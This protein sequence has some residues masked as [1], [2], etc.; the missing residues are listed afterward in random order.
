MSKPFPIRIRTFLVPLAGVALYYYVQFAALSICAYAYNEDNTILLLSGHYG[1]FCILESVLMFLCLFIWLFAS[2]KS[3]WLT[4][5]KDN[6]SMKRLL[7]AIPIAMAM[8]GLVNFYM[9]GFQFLSEQFPLIKNSLDEYIRNAS[10][11]QTSMGLEAAGY[12]IGVGILIPVIE[13]LVFRGII[14]GEFLSTMNAD[15]AVILSALIFGTMHM[16]PV[17]VGYALVCGLIL[18]YVYLYSNSLY[19]SIAIHIIF[20]ILGGVAPAIFTGNPQFMNVLG[21]LELVFVFAGLFC[22]LYLRKSYRKKLT[23]EV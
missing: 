16:Q 17:Q 7:I 20:N 8:L 1:S 5:R 15:I 9:M 13:E 14:L 21:V 4:V 19:L 10:I 2:R 3:T 12:Y 23:G 22:I 11:A 6:L 18:G